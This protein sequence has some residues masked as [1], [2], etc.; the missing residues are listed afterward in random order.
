MQKRIFKTVWED[1]E[2]S[3]GWFGKICLLALLMFIPIFGQ[4]ILLAYFFG[5]AREIAWGIHEPLPRKLI[6]NE[7]GKFWKRGWR[8]ILLFIVFNL[9]PL[10]FII[11]GSAI[12]NTQVV[13]TIF[14]PQL[15]QDAGL[16][17]ARDVLITIGRILSIVCFILA[18]IGSMRIAIYDQLS[19]GFQLRFIWKMLR[20]DAG[21]IMRIVGMVLIVGIIGLVVLVLISLLCVYPIIYVSVSNAFNSTYPLQMLPYMSQDQQ[22]LFVIQALMSIGPVG[23]AVGLVIVYLVHLISVFVALLATRALGYWTKQ[24]EVSLWGDKNDPLPFEM[25]EK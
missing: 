25:R 18:A 12:Q 22:I 21:G 7:D 4:V 6:A 8:I 10:A 2:H 3:K 15:F 24:F 13:M 19:A 17:L 11:G 23:I 5:W 16:T 14:G 1:I 20:S 9:I